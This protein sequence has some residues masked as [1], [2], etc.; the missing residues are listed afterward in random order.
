MVFT[1]QILSNNI[2]IELRIKKFGVLVLKKG[3][4]VLSEG[5]MMIDSEKIKEVEKSGYKYLGILEQNKIKESKIKEN[6]QREYL[7]TTRLM[8]KSTLSDRIN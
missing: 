7:R 6:F 1:V 4:V 3:K 5:E 2:G 8:I